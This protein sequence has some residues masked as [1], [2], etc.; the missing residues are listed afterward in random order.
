[1]RAFAV[2]LLV[3][4]TA[5]GA[6]GAAGGGLVLE[7]VVVVERHGVRS[8]TRAPD[9]LA[10]YA[11]QP[12]HAWPVAPGI[13][14][15]HGRRDVALMGAWL[16][17]DYA[18]KGLWPASGPP[19][20]D[21]VYVWADGKDQRTRVS[22]QALID[23][24]FPGSGLKDAF[25]PEGA[26]DA[27]FDAV[28]AGECRLD[29]DLAQKAVVAEAGGDLDDPRPDY[30]AALGALTAV[31][32][33]GIPPD[34]AAHNTVTPGRNGQL[35]Y[36]GPLADAATSAENVYLE[37]VQ[38]F[39]LAEVGWGRASSPAAIAAFMP[40]HDISFDLTRRTPYLAARY[41]AVMMRDVLGALEGRAALP[42]QTAP[43][44]MAVFAG[45]DSNLANMAGI[46]GGRW[47]LPGQPDDTAPDTAL[48][49]E[50]WR[51]KSG[52]RYVRLAV[53]YQTIDQ[54][55]DETALDAAHP[56]GR[57]A[58]A[59]PGCADGPDDAC[60]LAAF[61]AL[62]AERLPPDCADRR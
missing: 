29:L 53:I 50:V 49:L 44:R 57:L 34:P 51:S 9:D 5:P 42:G 54:L 7:R 55:R 20:R 56:P 1:M 61:E 16:R 2:V 18:S 17:A 4:L 23:G 47:T 33:P 22:G 35:R 30:K 60:S 14:T 10:R 15:E 6:A 45:H 3:L 19:P 52:Q 31:L 8:P 41:G 32:K 59:V 39:P 27:A 25:G 43:A 13:L 28:S 36:A 21:A 26:S 38:G 12:W 62:V 37:Y 46:L 24:A 11:S 40:M 58:L 48:A